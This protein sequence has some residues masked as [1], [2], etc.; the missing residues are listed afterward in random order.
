MGRHSRFLTLAAA[1]AENSTQEIQHGSLLVR[2]GKVLG[3]GHNSS[4]SRLQTHLPGASN[5]ASLHS[6]VRAPARLASPS[7]RFFFSRPHVPLSR[8][9]RR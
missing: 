1:E 9:W 8:R 7:S 5:M 4:R 3:A 2:G 6:E